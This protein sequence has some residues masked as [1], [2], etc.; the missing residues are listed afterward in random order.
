MSPTKA[1]KAMKELKT[2]TRTDSVARLVAALKT[3]GITRLWVSH[4]HSIGAGVD[5]E[6]YRLS[7]DEGGTYT[8]KAKVEFVAPADEV[9]ALLEVIREYG[10]TGHRGDGV[11]VLTDVSGV[12]NVRTGDRD[13]LALL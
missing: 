9:D 8:E 6:D 13:R 5:P 2:I 11:V 7:F 10:G 12:V 1:T 3:A 4:V